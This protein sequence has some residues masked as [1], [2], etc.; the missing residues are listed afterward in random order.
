VQK[1]VLA[2][3]FI[4]AAGKRTR[5]RGLDMPL[6]IVYQMYIT[7][8]YEDAHVFSPSLSLLYRYVFVLLFL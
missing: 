3:V 6:L 2:R 5:S 4:R 7:L 8:D 1:R